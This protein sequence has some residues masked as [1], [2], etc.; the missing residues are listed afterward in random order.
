MISAKPYV[1]FW[2]SLELAVKER[3]KER[4]EYV[5]KPINQYHKKAK[6]ILELGCGIGEVLVNLPKKYA[7]QGLDIE[8]DYIEVCRKRIPNGKFIVASMHNF[9]IDEKFDVIFCVGDA[10]NFLRKFAQWKSTFKSVNNHLNEEGLFI[11]E[12]ETPRI[13]KAANSYRCTKMVTSGVR[14]FSKGYRYDIGIAKD[15]TLTWDERIFERLP[16]GLFQLN[17]YKFDETIYPVARVRQALSN[18]FEILETNPME[19]GRIVVFACRK[20]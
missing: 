11:L 12:T 1:Y 5:L 18:Y 15:N 6:K 3:A 20:K 14:E 10:I 4:A 16:N 2:E 17:K 9:K 19:K 7:V 13:L 8:K